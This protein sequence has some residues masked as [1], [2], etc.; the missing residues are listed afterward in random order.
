M[1]KYI[2]LFFLV[3]TLLCSCHNDDNAPNGILKK[4]EMVNVL[5]DV[6]LVDGSLINLP[7]APDTLYKYGT[8]R[9]LAV[10]TKHHTDSTQFR[11]SFKYYSLN[12]AALADIYDNVTKKLQ[13][14]TDS[15]TKLLAAQ[16]RKNHVLP[17]TTG[18]RV[19][20]PVG[21]APVQVPVRGG[22][23]NTSQQAI[24]QFNAK[25]DS[26]MKQSLKKENALPK[27]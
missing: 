10:F 17:T 27:K 13:A 6:H 15:L 20:P 19:T 2:I 18:G 24:M 11:K 7:Q 1:H 25:R 3:L 23:V 4:S 22:A 8:A 9:Y 5:I 16:N 26:A 21:P 14:K 12:P